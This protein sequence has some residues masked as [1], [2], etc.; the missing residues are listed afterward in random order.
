MRCLGSAFTQRIKSMI[1]V[2][3]KTSK[4]Q[5]LRDFSS[6]REKPPTPIFLTAVIT[7]DYSKRAPDLRRALHSL[8]GMAHQLPSFNSHWK[9]LRDL[10]YQ[11]TASLITLLPKVNRLPVHLASYCYA[12]AFIATMLML[13]RRFSRTSVSQCQ[14]AYYSPIHALTKFMVPTRSIWPPNYF[15]SRSWVDARCRTANLSVEALFRDVIQGRVE[16]REPVRNLPLIILEQLR[17][18]GWRFG[19]RIDL[20]NRAK[21]LFRTF[22]EKGI[23]GRNVRGCSS[24]V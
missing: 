20:N 17:L 14:E 11:W 19:L 10:A 24:Y 12:S 13:Y 3:R 16:L 2:R 23:S 6:S 21:A 22:W 15:N 8:Y 7:I 4:L 9:A 1:N 5:R 18:G